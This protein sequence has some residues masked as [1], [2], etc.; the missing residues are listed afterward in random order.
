MSDEPAEEDIEARFRERPFD[1]F[2]TP[3]AT[4]VLTR[5]V[6]LRVLGFVWFFAFLAIAVEGIPLF[7]AHGLLPIA[8]VVRGVEQQSSG[9]I[10]S[11]RHVPSIFFLVGASD[12]AIRAVAWLGVALAALVMAG[13]TN[14]GAIVALWILYASIVNLGQEFTGYGWEIQIL[15][16]GILAAFL[17]PMTS[18]RPFPKTPPPKVI[19]W[20]FRWLIVRIMLGA[21]LIKV[22]HDP[23]WRNFTCL[24]FHY[25]TQPVPNPLSWLLDKA[26]L[27]LHELGVATNHLVELVLPFFAFG[28]R[29][30]RT[31]AGIGFIAFQL[32]LV[33]SGNLSFLNWLTIV[34]AIACFDD[35]ALAKVLPRSFVRHAERSTSLE[36]PSRVHHFVALGYGLAIAVLSLE[37]IANLLSSDQAMNRSFEPLRLV[38]TYGAFG[39]VDRV[40]D[41]VVLEGTAATELDG[42]ERW[43]PYELPCK[44]GDVTRRPCVITPY[45]HRFDWQFWFLHFEDYEDEG[46][47]VHLEAKLLEGDRT[48]EPLFAHDPFPNAPPKFVRASL[49]RYEFSGFGDPSGAWW[50]RRYLR[51]YAPAVSLDDPAFQYDVERFGWGR[52]LGAHVAPAR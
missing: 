29:V 49:Y 13:L 14:A 37:P 18:A 52:E 8:D 45:H 31:A 3:R 39:T 15:E 16:T 23:C 9:A 48:I 28:P 11:M 32:V 33:S 20:A 38:N 43:L 22:R 26:P 21:G 7:G 24:A 1:R 27:W 36:K 41:E 35:Q 4:F 46:W 17:C 42:T 34:P 44:P 25:E 30:A 2:F 50:K 5:F 10:D 12:T 51:E 47:F 19:V 40:R 6:L